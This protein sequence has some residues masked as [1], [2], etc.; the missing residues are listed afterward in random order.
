MRLFCWLAFLLLWTGPLSGQSPWVMGTYPTPDRPPLPSEAI[1]PLYIPPQAEANLYDR[2]SWLAEQAP[3]AARWG[4][5]EVPGQYLAAGFKVDTAGIRAAA[6]FYATPFD[7][8]IEAN[9][10]PLIHWAYLL[11]KMAIYKAHHTEQI[12]YA[13]L[14]ACAATFPEA[15]ADFLLDPDYFL[16]DTLVLCAQFRAV[17]ESFLAVM[18]MGLPQAYHEAGLVPSKAWGDLQAVAAWLRGAPAAAPM[19]TYH[20]IL[21]DSLNNLMRRQAQLKAHLLDQMDY[22]RIQACGP[23]FPAEADSFI[24]Q[25]RYFLSPG[26]LACL[27]SRADTGGLGSL[28]FPGDLETD[29]EWGMEDE[30]GLPD[31]YDKEPERGDVFWPELQGRPLSMQMLS[32]LNPTTQL[33]D[34]AAQFLVDRTR[35]E[36]VTAFFE[37]FETRMNQLPELRLLFPQTYLLLQGRTYLYGPGLGTGWRAAMA[38][39]LQHLPWQVE[40]MVDELPQYHGLRDRADYQLFRSAY[41]LHQWLGEGNEDI[42]FMLANLLSQARTGPTTYL[43]SALNM[44]QHSLLHL[45]SGTGWRPAEDWEKLGPAGRRLFVALQYRQQPAP[46]DA[47]QHQGGASLAEQMQADP[48]GFLRLERAIVQRL[49]LAQSRVETLRYGLHTGD[50]QAAT[51]WLSGIEALR[52]AVQAAYYWKYPQDPVAILDDPGYL[53]LTRL[54]TVSTQMLVAKQQQD[55]HQ[56]ALA[57]LQQ[58]PVLIDMASD[59]QRQRLDRWESR[60]ALGSLSADTVARLQDQIGRGQRQLDQLQAAATWVGFYGNLILELHHAR[61]ERQMKAILEKYALPT[62]SYRL[63]RAHRWSLEVAAYPGLYAGGEVII[64]DPSGREQPGLVSGVTAPIGLSLSRGL[65]A[66]A[67]GTGL[68]GAAAQ[69]GHALSLFLPVLD[70]AA[71]FSYRWQQGPA[72]GLPEAISWQ[73]VLA[74]GAYVVWGI[75]GA[76]VALMAGG[77]YV[78]QLRRIDLGGNTLVPYDALRL[79]IQATVDIPVFTLWRR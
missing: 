50:D 70:I 67:Q 35:Q 13:W 41:F 73:Q 53:R 28:I 22:A 64:R 20:L 3:V 57:S 52:L 32:S 68:P 31:L 39:D 66:A 33:I 7:T 17:A 63:K 34:A 4:D 42:F 47:L 75:R 11:E 43:D 9:A 79:G 23:D 48:E 44:N 25:A 18:E 69:S 60:L 6:A 51:A 46:F 76:P 37:R 8:S 54:L 49:Q 77:Q 27:S 2:A 71:P 36:L 21:I 72:E 16:S 12:G 30:E 1:I 56:I 78:P 15:E 74:P 58:V 19:G 14:Q 40:Q 10:D 5:S 24:A 55:P 59:W 38:Q 26:T 61:D 29:E 45:R 65:G 62:G